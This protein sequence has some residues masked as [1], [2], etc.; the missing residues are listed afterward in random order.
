MDY[1]CVLVYLDSIV[2]PWVAKDIMDMLATQV[3]HNTLRSG[4]AV[5][6]GKSYGGLLAQEFALQYPQQIVSLVLFAPASTNHKENAA[7]DRLC[8]H[9]PALPIFLGWTGDDSSY[10]H[11]SKFLRACTHAEFLFHSEL[12]GGHAITPEYYEPITKFLA[13]YKKH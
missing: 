13:L 4:K 2:K 10:M 12:Y 6:L 8:K 7:I 5:I 3:L 9:R 11:R 1:V